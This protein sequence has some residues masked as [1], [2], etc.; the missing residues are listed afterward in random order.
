MSCFQF[1]DAKAA[2]KR[3]YVKADFAEFN[4]NL[5]LTS[6]WDYSLNCDLVDNDVEYASLYCGGLGLGDVCPPSLE[7]RWESASKRMK[8]YLNCFINAR[9]SLEEHCFYDMVP[10]H[11][12]VE[13]FEVK[14]RIAAHVL[15]HYKRP[16]N[17]DFLL[18]LTK[19]TTEIEER[20]LRFNFKNIDTVL[21]LRNIN[22]NLIKKIN[23][24]KGKISYNIY[25]TR[26]GRLTTNAG[27]F[28]ILTLKKEFRKGI[29]PQN[30]L[31]VEM[32]FNAAELR[33]L[34][35]LCGRKQPGED[36]HQWN[37]KNVF[38]GLLTREEAKTRIFSW[39]YNSESKDK[40]PN[41]TYDRFAVIKKHW[42][43]NTVTTPFGRKIEADEFHALNYLIQSTTSDL[44]LRRVLALHHML[45]GF[46]SHIAF[47]VHDSVVIDFSNEDKGNL[48]KMI[49][50]FGETSLGH[51][52]T[53][54]A[55][56]K[57][58]GSLR[59]IL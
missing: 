30:D 1:I 27:S 55:V 37:V 42:D 48:K 2:C 47:T 4:K 12:L 26:T 52:K 23:N 7:D 31:F 50:T 14:S 39:M 46:K 41:Q 43:G 13:F 8:A 5:D 35:S 56:G 32:D 17:Y 9:V 11:F 45:K 20:P 58:Y 25:G 34:L 40:L 18:Q 33:T 29:E 36:I 6:T 19:L 59:Q 53:N 3:V 38:G 57:T 10:H 49:E 44:F 15:G 54:V 24:S 22:K 21:L 28:P 51:F 16:S